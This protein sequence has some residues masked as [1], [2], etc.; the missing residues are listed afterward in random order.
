MH[1][2]IDHKVN[3]HEA[4]RLGNSRAVEILL[5]GENVNSLDNNRRTPLSWAA[6]SGQTNIVELLLARNDVDVNCEDKDGRTAL[7]W[8]AG[9]GHKDVVKLLLAK[10]GIDVNRKDNR[11]YTPLGHAASSG[12]KL[13]VELLLTR[14][15]INVN[16][17]DDRNRTPLLQAAVFRSIEVVKLL[18]AR[19]DIDMNI[20][21]IE[22]RTPLW[23]AVRNG[24]KNMLKLLLKKQC[25][26]CPGRTPLSWAAENGHHYV[27][28]VLLDDADPNF[29]DGDGQTA[30]SRAVHNRRETVVEL[31][32]P[33]DTITLHQ[34]VKEGDRAAINLLLSNEYDLNTRDDRGET[35][36]HFAVSLG[37][38]EIA[39]DLISCGAE[40]NPQDCDGLTPLRL[41]MQRRNC[42][43]IQELLKRKARVD[44]ITAKEWRDAYGKQDRDIVQLSEGDDGTKRVDFVSDFHELSN[45]GIDQRIL[46]L[47]DDSD[48]LLWSKIPIPGSKEPLVP[49]KLHVSL[50]RKEAEGDFAVSVSLLFPAEQGSSGKYFSVP[51]GGKS[52]IAWK[53]RRPTNP[54]SEAWR[55]IVY[56]STLPYGWI[57]SDGMDLFKQF[58]VH[59]KERWLGL[60]QQAEEHLSERRLGQLSSKGKNPKLIDCLASDAQKW[61][62]LRTILLS[63]AREARKFV[64]DYCQYYNVNSIP[65]ELML[66]IDEFEL[67]INNQ[68]GQL[69]QTVRDLLQIEFAWVSVTETRIATR[70]GQNMMLLTYVNIFY[71]PLAVCAALWAIPD[72]QNSSTRNP[73]IIT[74]VVV[75]L[76]TF[77]V[78]FNMENVKGF[79]GNVCRQWKEHIV[80]SRGEDRGDNRGE[81]FQDVHPTQQT[82]S[83]VWLVGDSVH[84]IVGWLTGRK[85]LSQQKESKLDGANAC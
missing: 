72:I 8:A 28:Q 44:R 52:R 63:Q 48:D 39:L 21:D 12:R 5:D 58:I 67:S 50:P 25:A 53:I 40:I 65:K 85:Q 69:D 51:T 7:S 71:L 27:V 13:T 42:H 55:P 10:D 6:E 59:L 84:R 23:W 78:A 61:T 60:C 66:L 41:A 83:E 35:P 19:N 64:N 24:Q 47:V 36:L 14:D 56:F 30:L 46:L 16:C 18:L 80:R 76:I 29:R 77:L 74:S 3:L 11:D 31:L 79:M 45:S 38:L 15:D 62:E 9:R 43:L 82:P 33:V 4:A 37:H 22:G 81:K 70:L 32:A 1:L 20:E 26:L 54:K 17:K 2:K 68:I 73:F 75:G 49:N 34:L 57:P